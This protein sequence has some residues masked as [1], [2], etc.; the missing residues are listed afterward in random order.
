VGAVDFCD[1]AGVF[2]DE[3]AAAA[4]N[5]TTPSG[6]AAELAAEGSFV[7]AAELDAPCCGALGELAAWL[8]GSASA[9]PVACVSDD[10][11]FAIGDVAAAFFKLPEPAVFR[12]VKAAAVG[13]LPVGT[14]LAG[15]LAAG[16]CAGACE[17]R[18]PSLVPF[19]PASDRKKAPLPGEADETEFS[20][21]E[22]A[23][24][25]SDAAG[26]PTL[27]IVMRHLVTVICC[28]KLPA[29]PLRPVANY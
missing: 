14:G 23:G 28:S 27:F 29:V 26:I 24:V 6:A 21:D 20:G 1:C 17:D 11:E 15:V 3:L 25:T 18:L 2:C 7:P 8:P 22:D 12:F 10:G 16:A 4:S 9:E 5:C 13:P 19:E